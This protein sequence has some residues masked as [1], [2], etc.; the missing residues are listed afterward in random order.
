MLEVATLYLKL[1]GV[2]LDCR[3]IVAQAILAILPPTDAAKALGKAAKKAA[4]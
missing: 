4:S 2:N 1:A 3:R